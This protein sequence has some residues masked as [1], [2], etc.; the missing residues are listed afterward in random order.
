MIGITSKIIQDIPSWKVKL[1][2]KIVSISEIDQHFQCVCVLFVRSFI[3]AAI[4]GFFR[5]S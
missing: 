5:A 3:L 4:V 1:L 2:Q